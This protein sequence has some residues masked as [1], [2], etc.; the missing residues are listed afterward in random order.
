M[1]RLATPR[2]MHLEGIETETCKDA[3]ATE[4]RATTV[5]LCVDGDRDGGVWANGPVACYPWV[6]AGADPYEISRH[7]EEMTVDTCG[8]C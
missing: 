6:G 8:I 4:H 5:S 2:R 1:C 7:M 3:S